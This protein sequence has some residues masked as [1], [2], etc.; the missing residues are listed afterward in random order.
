VKG[1]A[2][3]TRADWVAFLERVYEPAQDDVVWARRLTDLGRSVF[4]DAHLFGFAAM[5]HD[6][7]CR[8]LEPLVMLGLPHVDSDLS[9]G[10][11]QV[12]PQIM[13]AMFYPPSV[14][15]THVELSAVLPERERAYMAEFRKGWGCED[16]LGLCVHPEPGTVLAFYAGYDHIVSLTRH[17]RHL[18]TQMAL[19]VETGFRLRQR[20]ESVKAIVSVDGRLLHRE[21]GAPAAAAVRA[22]V[23]RVE[24]ARTRRHRKTAEA[25]DLWT[26]L[27]AGRASLV[28]R[29]EGPRREYLVVENAPA[30][31]PIRALTSGEIDVVSYAARGLP[32]KL[33]AYALGISEPTVSSRLQA[34]AAKIGL[35]TRMDLVRIAAM[36]TRDPRARFE[37][38]AL[39]TAEREVHEL[40]SRGLSNRQIAAIRNRSVRTIAN[41]VAHLLRKTGS[42]TRRALVAR[43]P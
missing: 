24:R 22:H 16:G 19:H 4:G 13:H 43:K 29:M 27:V 34:A 25:I 36:L 3:R 33:V 6:A 32:A 23:T 12:G 11:D 39:T 7:A 14:V 40:V 17:E 37:D 38:V 8:S 1:G 2:V 15:T 18:L 30:T 28:E 9:R 42:P 10:I 41:Q 26:T 35:A 21:E 5:K 20:P 31:Q